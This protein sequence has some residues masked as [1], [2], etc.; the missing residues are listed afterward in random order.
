VQSSP[1]EK[2]V[3]EYYRRQ[4][5][6]LIREAG[7]L[8]RKEMVKRQALTAEINIAYAESLKNFIKEDYELLCKPLENMVKDSFEKFKQ[9]E[10]LGKIIAEGFTTSLLT[11][12]QASLIRPLPEMVEHIKKVNSF[13]DSVVNPIIDELRNEGIYLHRIEPIT[14]PTQINIPII[15]KS[16]RES[17][18]TINMAIG[19]L[20][21]LI[22]ASTQKY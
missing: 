6:K 7:T 20:K 10:D 3:E 22:E 21:G 2:E 1:T 5:V 12:F 19:I 15:T 4:L 16:L 18:H 13:L 11:T 8:I 14:L 9:G 17:L